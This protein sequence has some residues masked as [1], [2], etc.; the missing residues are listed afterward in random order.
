MRASGLGIGYFVRVASIT[1]GLRI[2][3]MMERKGV[4]VIAGVNVQADVGE[5]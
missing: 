3:S 2:V 1:A 5:R 4:E